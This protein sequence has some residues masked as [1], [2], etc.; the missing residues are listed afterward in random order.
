VSYELRIDEAK[1][2]A[3]LA[4]GGDA[5][6]NNAAEHVLDASRQVVPIEE[7]VLLADS[8]VEAA[9][10]GTHEALVWY[11]R[12]AASRYAIVQHENIGQDGHVRAIPFRH[13][14]GRTDKFLERPL[15]EQRGAALAVMAVTLR[16]HL[17]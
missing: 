17:T 7:S 15:R 9:T 5:A 3:A 1:L 11:G 8:G 4:A 2:R 16:S 6:V 12:G 13:D 10:G 14:P